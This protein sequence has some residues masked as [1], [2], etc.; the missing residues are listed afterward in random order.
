[1]YPLKFEII[2]QGLRNSPPE[3]L[4][5][6]RK[7]LPRYLKAQYWV[8]KITGTCSRYGFRREF[9]HIEKDYRAA[10]KM[11]TRG[12]VGLCFLRD[13]Y[14]YEVSHQVYKGERTRYFC[15]IDR[16]EMIKINRQQVVKWLEQNS[17]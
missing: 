7:S 4:A 2:E 16:G 13:G 12:I 17:V 14:V 15:I 5:I 6:L 11:A 9:V 10:N 1:M 3:I 8:A